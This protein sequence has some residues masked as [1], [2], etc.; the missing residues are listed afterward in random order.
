MPNIKILTAVERRFYDQNGFLHCRA[1][2]EVHCPS[3][4]ERVKADAESRIIYEEIYK[5]D[6]GTTLKEFLIAL[7]VG[8][9]PGILFGLW[10]VYGR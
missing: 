7:A 6:S 10:W 2:Q 9:V 5:R 1:H 8:A 4:F 3:C